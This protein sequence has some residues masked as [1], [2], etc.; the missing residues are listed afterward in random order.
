[1]DRGEIDSSDLVAMLD[2]GL[3]NASTCLRD[4]YAWGLFTRERRGRSYYYMITD[5]GIKRY[6]WLLARNRTSVNRR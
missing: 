5:K 1:M 4:Y 2:M 6:W 3:T